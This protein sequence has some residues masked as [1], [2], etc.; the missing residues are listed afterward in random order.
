MSREELLLSVADCRSRNHVHIASEMRFKAMTAPAPDVLSRRDFWV[1]IC[2]ESGAS[3]FTNF[4]YFSGVFVWNDLGGVN[5]A[6]AGPMRHICV[7]FSYT[8]PESA[9]E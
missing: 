6:Q 5:G 3:K 4:S 1:G 7:L 8:E 2:L 9:W